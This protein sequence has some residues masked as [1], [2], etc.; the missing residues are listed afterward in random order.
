MQM[1]KEPPCLNEFIALICW[2][3]IISRLMTV[4]RMDCDF[5]CPATRTNHLRLRLKSPFNHPPTRPTRV[6][7]L[8]LKTVIDMNLSL[9]VKNDA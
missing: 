2:S 8:G 6:E 9:M 5:P 1:G 7:T 4:A 3:V